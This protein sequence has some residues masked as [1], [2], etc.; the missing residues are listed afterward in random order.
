MMGKWNRWELVDLYLG[1]GGET[2][3]GY[4]LRDLVFSL[5]FCILLSHVH[6]AFT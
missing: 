2:G 1:V 5:Y 6:I 3:C 4:H